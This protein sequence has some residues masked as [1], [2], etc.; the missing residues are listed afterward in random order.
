LACL[1]WLCASSMPIATSTADIQCRE[2]RIRTGEGNWTVQTICSD[3]GGSPGPAS[4]GDSGGC[5]T[6]D[7]QQVPC[8]VQDDSGYYWWSSERQTYCRLAIP[9]P[10]PGHSI[11]DGHRG[12]D[13][14]PQG[15]AILCAH[16]TTSG[17]HELQLHWIPSPPVLE[18]IATQ[19]A[20]SAV[21]SLLLHP[22]V[23]HLEG[24][25]R[26]EVVDLAPWLPVGAVMW[27]WVSRDDHQWG[28]QSTTVSEQGITVSLTAKSTKMT[29]DPGD[30]SSL[31]SCR[32]SGTQRYPASDIGDESPS[33]CD[34]RYVT[35]N[36]KDDESDRFH[37]TGFVTWTITWS[38]SNGEYGT[39]PID[40]ASTQDVSIR[41]GEL[42]AV[43]TR[44]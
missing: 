27:V 28:S 13:G 38:A 31:V 24:M 33:G 44:G 26:P 29:F 2:E 43:S 23:F 40:V 8:T 30:G 15:A 22:P 5:W 37:V 35:R 14:S 19:V 4:S 16:D 41:I 39:F 12:S 32:S 9:P 20:R 10:D 25:S 36:S 6:W 17:V 7:G 18:T 42:F 3:D 21:A 34:H 11:W 1:I